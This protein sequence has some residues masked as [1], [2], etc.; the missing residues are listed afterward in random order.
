[1]Q[2]PNCPKIFLGK[3]ICPYC[4]YRLNDADIQSMPKE[5]QAWLRFWEISEILK[6]K[7]YANEEEQDDLLT[8]QELLLFD[9]ERGVYDEDNEEFEDDDE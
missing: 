6:K 9:I 2:C 7:E 3:R 5:D 1:M 8:E 4:G